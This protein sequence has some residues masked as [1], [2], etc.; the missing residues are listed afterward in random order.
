M[1]PLNLNPA[2]C[3]SDLSLMELQK[4]MTHLEDT[5]RKPFKRSTQ[6]TKSRKKTSDICGVNHVQL[7]DPPSETPSQDR[8]L[9]YQAR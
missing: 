8:S 4:I 1:A 3:A 9:G 6:S 2:T 5:S 7:K